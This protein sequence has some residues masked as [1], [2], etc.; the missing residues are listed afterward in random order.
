[1]S[2]VVL[3]ALHYSHRP[4]AHGAPN[5]YGY[6][7]KTLY[8]LRHAKSSWDDHSLVDHD[9]P[10][11]GRGKH[12][13]RLIGSYLRNGGHRPELALCSTST[14]TRQ[15]LAA[16]IE[17]LEVEPAIDWDG[18]LYLAD[19][20]LMLDLLRAVSDTVDAVLMVGH[21]PGTAALADLLCAEGNASDLDLLRTKFPTA[22]LAI[23]DLQVDRWEQVGRDRG[24]LR[25][26]LRPR[27]LM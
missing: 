13:A 1:M 10:L 5:V 2:C 23:I 9:R 18:D 25:C 12:S 15:T 26:F 22:G 4:L 6:M 21:N 14:R 17:E 19:A 7:M 3:G 24:R 16:V 20:E 11:N 27:E 8:L